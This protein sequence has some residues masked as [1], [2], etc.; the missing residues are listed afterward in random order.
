MLMP[1]QKRKGSDV[2][3][4]LMILKREDQRRYDCYILVVFELEKL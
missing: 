3:F 2:D 4:F 1:F